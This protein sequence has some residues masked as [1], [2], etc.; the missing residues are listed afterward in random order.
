[1]WFYYDANGKRVAFT[2][3]NGYYY[4]YIYNAMGDVIGLYDQYGDVIYYHYDSWGKLVSITNVLGEE[5]T[6]GSAK[7]TIAQENPFRYRGYMYD[8]NTMLYYLNSR[9][10]DP[11]TGRFINADAIVSTDSLLGANLYAYCYN[12]PVNL[13]DPSGYNPLLGYGSCGDWVKTLQQILNCNGYNL[14]VDG[15]FGPKTKAAVISYQRANGLQ[16]DG[17]VGPETWAALDKL[18]LIGEPNSVARTPSGGQERFYGPDGKATK[19]RD[20]GHANHHPNLPSPHEHDWT[21][22]GNTPTRGPARAPDPVSPKSKADRD[23]RV[24]IGDGG[25]LGSGVLGSGV[26]GGGIG[27]YKRK[28]YTI[29]FF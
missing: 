26:L 20:Y 25:V 14:S 29:I 6:Y 9:Y 8:N 24:I 23:K 2:D 4:Y 16:V 3:Y 17:I 5:I 11:E 27:G 21:W 12:N 18:P 13:C 28:R 15:I 10:Y 1:M 19:D 7:W 22:N